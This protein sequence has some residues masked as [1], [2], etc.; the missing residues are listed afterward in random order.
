M[1]KEL[2]EGTCMELWDLYD[3]DGNRTGTLSAEQLDDIRLVAMENP[4]P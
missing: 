4:K 1:G 3:R 2:S